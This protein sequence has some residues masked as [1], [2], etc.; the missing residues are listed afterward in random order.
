[1]SP[2]GQCLSLRHLQ[3]SQLSLPY[4]LWVRF[5]LDFC[6]S[7]LFASPDFPLP[8][9][10]PSLPALH[11]LPDTGDLLMWLPPCPSVASCTLCRELQ[12]GEFMGGKPKASHLC[13]D[14]SHLLPATPRAGSGLPIAPPS[15]CSPFPPQADVESQEDFRVPWE[16]VN[17]GGSISCIQEAVMRK[18][19]TPPSSL[20]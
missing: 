13:S 20:P 7:D 18:Y 2:A 19:R 3:L 4:P 11:S 14:V 8:P 12:R 1:M 9:C 10:T 16:L 15:R 5:S 6:N 17:Q